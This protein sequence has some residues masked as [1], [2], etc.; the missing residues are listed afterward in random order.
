[1]L[2]PLAVSEELKQT[3]KIALHDIDVKEVE[4]TEK[5]GIKKEDALN[6]AKWRDGVQKNMQEMD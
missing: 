5:I 4:E 6:Q 1:M 3:D 2:E